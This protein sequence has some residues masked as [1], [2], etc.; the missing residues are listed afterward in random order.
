MGLPPYVF[1]EQLKRSA[2]AFL[3][4][5]HIHTYT[6]TK[7]THLLSQHALAS[8]S[9]S[10]DINLRPRAYTTHC[11]FLHAFLSRERSRS[12]HSSLPHSNSHVGRPPTLY[13][14]SLLVS[15]YMSKTSASFSKT[16]STLNTAAPSSVSSCPLSYSSQRLISTFIALPQQILLSHGRQRWDLSMRVLCLRLLSEYESGEARN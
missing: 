8:T 10:K 5:S 6:H 16:Q 11:L 13:H 2:L 7:P 4:F 3:S 12:Y 15:A 1:A 9:G 14:A